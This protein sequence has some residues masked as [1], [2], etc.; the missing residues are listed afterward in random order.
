MGR[1][2]L[3]RVV[4]LYFKLHSP[5]CLALCSP[6]GMEGYKSE[7]ASHYSYLFVSLLVRLKGFQLV[8]ISLQWKKKSLLGSVIFLTCLHRL[9]VPTFN[10]HVQ[11]TYLGSLSKTFLWIKV[12]SKRKSVSH[13]DT[14]SIPLKVEVAGG[15]FGRFYYHKK[16][17]LF[18][19]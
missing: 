10:F 4:S 9:D 3:I 13:P 16:L 17:N 8:Y 19:R 15:E 5:A 6:Q 11:Q 18:P 1:M 14:S 12:I 7:H 2:T